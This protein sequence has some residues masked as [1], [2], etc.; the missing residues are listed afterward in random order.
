MKR[1]HAPSLLARLPFL[2]RP[3]HSIP[4]SSRST[5]LT[6]SDYIALAAKAAVFLLICTNLVSLLPLTP[7]TYAAEDVHLA[8]QTHDWRSDVS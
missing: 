5:Q 4:V 3:A 7:L 8:I 2:H 6:Q 1:P